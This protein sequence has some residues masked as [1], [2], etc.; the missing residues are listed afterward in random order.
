M[1]FRSSTPFVKVVHSAPVDGVEIVANGPTG[2]PFVGLTWEAKNGKE[3][4]WAWLPRSFFDHVVANHAAIVAAHDSAKVAVD[5]A[6]AKAEDDAKAAKA[7]KAPVTAA[8]AL[9]MMRI[10]MEKARAEQAAINAAILDALTK[11]K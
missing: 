9:E 2:Q 6:K 7:A 10:E 1:A 5:A 11:G 8:S 3:I 4:K